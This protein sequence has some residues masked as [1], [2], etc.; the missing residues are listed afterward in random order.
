MPCALFSY[1]RFKHRS[2]I[3]EKIEDRKENANSTKLCGITFIFVLMFHLR[4]PT[5]TCTCK[6]VIKQFEYVY[7]NSH[8]HIYF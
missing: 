2:H 6:H 5:Y 1:G 7:G 8:N 3:N 4:F